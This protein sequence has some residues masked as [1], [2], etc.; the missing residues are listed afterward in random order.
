MY[1]ISIKCVHNPLFIFE[2]I[3]L[4]YHFPFSFPPLTWSI[5][6]ACSLSNYGPFLFECTMYYIHVCVYI[7]IYISRMKCFESGLF[8]RNKQ[9]VLDSTLKLEEL[10]LWETHGK[11]WTLWLSKKENVLTSLC[12]SHPFSRQMTGLKLQLF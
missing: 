7:Y 2:I 5:Y 12:T 3:I 10:L 6:S 8:N 4:L 1:F 9:P 11:V